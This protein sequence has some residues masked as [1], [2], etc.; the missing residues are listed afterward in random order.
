M[1]HENICGMENSSLNQDHPNRIQDTS[2]ENG[3]INSQKKD[4][5]Q[6][7][8]FENNV[9]KYNTA[10]VI[11]SESSDA[12]NSAP[13][14]LNSVMCSTQQ[15][16]E[17]DCILVI[18]QETQNLSA[19][20]RLQILDNSTSVGDNICQPSTDT[21]NVCMNMLLSQNSNM[22]NASSIQPIVE[23]ESTCRFVSTDQDNMAPRKRILLNVN[24]ES[25]GQFSHVPQNMIS[26]NTSQ[27]LK[28]QDYE[29]DLYFK[30]NRKKKVQLLDLLELGKIKP[31]DDVL[32]F[33]LQDSKHKASLLGNGKV[34][35]GSNSV[36]QNPVQWIKAILGNDICVS[37]KYVYN[38]VTY[39]GRPLSTIV[40]EMNDPKEPEVLLQQKNL[41]D[42]S[43]QTNSS[44]TPCFLQFNK[45]M[46]ITDEEFLPWHAGE[47][48]WDFYVKCENFGF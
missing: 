39:C 26:Q 7:L 34:Q 12:T 38:K 6:L 22:N 46:L 15:L 40:N 4:G 8:V 41:L 48:Y 18:P 14:L 16:K 19:T 13:F 28:N 2:G 43:Y 42:S 35:T 17:I 11:N 23:L 3:E 29:R 20:S 47:Q 25:P 45:I 32:E 37:W 9:Q 44:K 36:Y 1:G 30:K 24:L 33:T 5:P 10:E 31:G 21:Q 27:Y